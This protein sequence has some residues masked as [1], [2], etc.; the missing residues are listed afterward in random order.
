MIYAVVF[1]SDWEDIEYFSSFELAK[2]HLA[3][4]SLRMDNFHPVLVVYIDD[5]SGSFESKSVY[6]IKDLGALKCSDIEEAIG[7]I[8]EIV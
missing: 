6:A 5:K 4:Y 2:R 3:T 1:G 8:E 7:L